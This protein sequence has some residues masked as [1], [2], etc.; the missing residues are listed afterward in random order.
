MTED[1]ALDESFDRTYEARVVRE[2]P[3]NAPT[4]WHYPG[5]DPRGGKDGMIVRVTPASGKS[6]VSMFTFGYDAGLTR[7]MTCPD[8]NWL[9]VI[10]RGTACLVDSRS[11]ERWH[12]VTEWP[13]MRA[14]PV[15]D[16]NLLI[17][18][19]YTHI[20]AWGASGLAWRSARL[21]YD[22][23]KII[24]I[25][26]TRLQGKG[27]EPDVEVDFTLDLSTGGHSGGPSFTYED[28]P[29]IG[30]SGKRLLGAFMNLF[31]GREKN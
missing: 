17:F 22:E 3:G 19:G 25:D 7:L 15:P 28:E 9:C 2:L 31:R 4:V 12:E 5:A 21:S 13:V 27:W 10:S 29:R 23:I 20:C 14:L 18:A 8:P 26:G 6:W 16:A 11:P 30:G 24:G 1:Y